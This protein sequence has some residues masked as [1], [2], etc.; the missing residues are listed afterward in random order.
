MMPAGRTAYYYTCLSVGVITAVSVVFYVL[1]V[2][3]PEALLPYR[4]WLFVSFLSINGALIYFVGQRYAAYIRERI[5]RT[6]Q[7]E[8]AFIG[9]ASHE[10][11]NPLTAIQGECEIT[12]MRERTP[13]EYQGSL[14]R[15]LS[16]SKR[17]ILLM[18]HLMFLSK[19]EEEIL[20]TASEPV[21]LAEFLM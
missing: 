21:F 18:K 10:L 12:L 17:I 9:N 15:I 7:S 14:Q 16:D 1:L 6:Y 8:K 19:G 3:F 2:L 4:I 13:A 20:K 11:N 5:D